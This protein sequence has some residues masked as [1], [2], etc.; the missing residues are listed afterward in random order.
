MQD[1]RL[2]LSDNLTKLRKKNKYTQVELANKLGFSDKAISK[3]E[4]GDTIP[5]IETIK[6]LADLYGITIDS[7][8]EEMPEE[9]EKETKEKKRIITNK[10]IIT[11]LAVTV[12]WTGAIVWFAIVKILNNYYFWQAFIWAL[13]LSAVI[14]LIFNSIWGHRKF[15]Y[16]IISIILWSTCLSVH[17]QF[18]N[19]TL[20]LLYLVAIPAQVAIILAS[21]LT[22]SNKNK[23]H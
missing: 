18:L 13:P 22:V 14:I 3:W 1:I 12:I 4:Q 9:T 6:K 17:M 7:L 19:Y 5:D 11:L 15:N 23:K 10:I 8:L 2:I 20:W 16:L 21:Q